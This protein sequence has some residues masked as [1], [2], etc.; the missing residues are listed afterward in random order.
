MNQIQI[1]TTADQLKDVLASLL[2]QLPT[3]H[4][5]PEV[6]ELELLSRKEYLT[7]E[8]VE[9]LYP[10]KANTL[11]KRR[12]NGEGPAYTKDGDKVVYSRTA[13]RKYLESRRQRT[14]DQP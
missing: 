14:N 12:M 3:V 2:G 13:I 10:L 8:E 1:I 6:V 7:T 11:R 5:P 9:K 4:L